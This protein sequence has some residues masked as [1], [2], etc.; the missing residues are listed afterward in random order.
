MR[1]QHHLPPAVVARLYDHVP[2]LMSPPSPTGG[3]TATADRMRHRA[4]AAALAP[5]KQAI[6]AARAAERAAGLRAPDASTQTARFENP[7]I[8]PMIPET[9]PADTSA[10]TAPFKPSRIDPMDREPAAKPAPTTPF[11]PSRI[12]PMDREP[13]AFPDPDPQ[14]VHRFHATAH[15][16]E[17]H[18]MRRTREA[19][20]AGKK[21]FAADERR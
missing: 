20:A 5:W 3:I 21:F 7:R 1:D 19:S 13:G 16:L 11:K 12:D 2:E 10:Q 17:R 6:A 9:P 18:A 14:P 4:V 8:Y 15:L